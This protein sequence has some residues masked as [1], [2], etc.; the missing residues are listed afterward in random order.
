[1]GVSSE[2]GIVDRLG[3]SSVMDMPAIAPLL[4][5]LFTAPFT[6]YFWAIAEKRNPFVKKSAIVSSIW[7]TVSLSLLFFGFLLSFF[8]FLVFPFALT[9]LLGVLSVMV[10]LCAIASGLRDIYYGYPSAEPLHLG[11][12]TVCATLYHLLGGCPEEDMEDVEVLL[13]SMDVSVPF[14]DFASVNL[15]KE[16][17]TI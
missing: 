10:S 4:L 9:I 13:D 6:S 3:K 15:E 1:M 11:T 16:A 5:F 17:E 12:K 8:T 7:G 2:K 14:D